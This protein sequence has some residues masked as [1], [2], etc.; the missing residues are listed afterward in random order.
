MKNKKEK[1]KEGKC[2]FTLKSRP[3]IN[4]PPLR[5]FANKPVICELI[6]KPLKLTG[7]PPDPINPPHYKD[8]FNGQETIESMVAIWGKDAVS[9][10]CAITAFKYRARAGKKD[11]AKIVEDINKAM[12]FEARAKELKG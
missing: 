9:T 7:T 8:G 3:D 5:S 1:Y 2:A 6:F 4:I 11:P 10:Y 12:W